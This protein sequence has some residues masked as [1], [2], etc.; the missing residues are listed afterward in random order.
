M[1]KILDVNLHRKIRKKKKIKKY[2][3]IILLFF[4]IFLGVFAVWNLSLK[5]IILGAKNENFPILFSGDSVL[6]FQ[7]TKTGFCVL[8]NNQFNFYKNDGE[9]VRNVVKNSLKTRINS[10]GYDVLLFEKGAKNFSIHNDKKEIFSD[11]L[12]NNIIFAKFFNKGYAFV[13]K[14]ED[15]SCELVVYNSRNEQ[16]YKWSCAEG[17]I[18]DFD[19][20]NDF[21]TCVVTTFGTKEG[22]LRSY[23]YELNFS[24]AGEKFKKEFLKQ[25]P[26]A[27]KEFGSILVFVCENNVFFLDSNKNVINSVDFGKNL[28]NFELTD[29]GYFIGCFS[30]LDKDNFCENVVSYDKMGNKIAEIKINDK[31]RK[32]KS[33]GPDILIITDEEILHTN[34]NFRN[35][36]K[37]KSFGETKEIF[38]Y[39]PYLYF[40][41]MNKVNRVLLN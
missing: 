33:F 32:I 22:F 14:S 10:N 25:M 19:I 29:T 1:R 17:L 40:V 16:I 36:K 11:A 28:N 15:Y 23:I 39:K 27:I 4:F 5:R 6:G 18:I 21:K 13:T 7:K 35:I 38:Y 30:G 3:K 41:S 8:T 26:L 20:S 37:I 24:S 9:R 31:V 2:L 34:I 12:K